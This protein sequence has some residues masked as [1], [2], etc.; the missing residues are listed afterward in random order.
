MRLKRG[1]TFAAAVVGMAFLMLSLWAQPAQA[2]QSGVADA[3]G[4]SARY[5]VLID[6]DTAQVLY[7]KDCDAQAPMASTTKIMTALLLLE[8][9]EPDFSFAVTDEMV[10]VEGTSMGLRA[11]DNVSRYALACGMLLASGNDAAQAAAV[12]LAG[13]L[14]EFA[15]RMN[16]RAQEIGMTRTNF[17][18]PSGLDAQGHLSTAYDMA[19]LGREALL[20]QTFREICGQR[21]IRVSF[22]SP[23]YQRTLYNHN[24]LVRELDGCLGIKT[25]F[26]KKAGRCLVSAVERNG[27]TLIAVTLSAPSDWADHRK[28]YEYG[29]T[30]YRPIDL[31]DMSQPVARLPIAGGAVTQANV[32][33]AHDPIAYVR[34]MPYH[35]RR[36]IL[37]RPFEYAPLAAGKVVGS[38]RY[39]CDDLLL[40]EVPLVLEAPV[41]Q[42][43]PAQAPVKTGLWQRIKEFLFRR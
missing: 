20:N 3:L 27:R 16:E 1:C 30:Q 19:L 17:V 22:G 39:Y 28:L 38:A 34:V 23:A 9:G 12:H 36:E 42:E 11:G 37:L 21:A 18:T 4:L 15:L 10:R 41:E 7:A 35:I 43:R 5:A 32:K 29:F 8:A 31:D 6:A 25:G 14:T 26:T 33:L 2:A 13:S 24:R 40:A